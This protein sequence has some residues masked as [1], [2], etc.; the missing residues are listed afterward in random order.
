MQNYTTEEIQKMLEVALW[1]RKRGYQLRVPRDF[2]RSVNRQIRD[3]QA[4][5]VERMEA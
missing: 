2:I 5:L 1:Q 4:E 3:F